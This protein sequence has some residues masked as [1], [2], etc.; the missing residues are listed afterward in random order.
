[1]LF[2]SFVFLWFLLLVVPL[3]SLLAKRWRNPLLLIASYVFYGYWDWRFCG[4]L[5]LSTVVDY[6]AGGR[7]A[8]SESE[9]GRRRWLWVSL[10]TN[11]G[12]LG[13][14]KY[15]NFFA[16]SFLAMLGPYSQSLDFVHLNIILPVGI[17]FYTFQTLSYTIDIYRERLE[18]ARSFWDFALFVSFFPQLV[19]GPIER[20]RHLLPQI[21]ERRL[22][23]RA[24]VQEAMV[25]ITLGMFRKV[26]IG[27]TCG[28]YVD[29]LFAEPSAYASGELLAA[30]VLFSIQIY[31]DFS[32]Y[33]SIARGTAKLLGVDLMEN[34]NQPYLAQNITEFWRRWHISLSSWLRDY[35]YISLGGNRRGRVR[36]Y[37]NLMTTMLLG[38]LWHGANWTF[39][40]W[41]GLHGL[42]LAVHKVMLGDRA[43]R[44]HFDRW[45]SMRDV[46]GFLSRVLATNAL[47]LLT[48]LFF[49]AKSFDH[50]W[51][52]LSR[53][54]AFEGSDLTGRF[55][56]IATAYVFLSLALDLAEYVT[57]DH[58]WPLR[59]PYWLR[60]PAGLVMWAVV[61][62][63]MFVAPP[64]PFIYFQF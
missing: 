32:G 60:A 57:R 54:L 33:S 43:I 50:A 13:I 9:A 26:I 11:L 29:T 19:A 48:W 56:Q 16:D 5:A 12:I 59:T 63:Y 61:L 24:M 49:R 10:A 4:L 22:P 27:D 1:M 28:R 46:A 51:E 35:L 58:A 7:I 53:M 42:Y 17:S 25:L 23:D 39:V 45:R 34:F 52:I 21:A 55:V 8:A 18:P 20:A 44:E 36:T 47:V 15:Y 31:A 62:M 3:H 30:L 2:N 40:V 14:F 38:G 6:I 64:M 41:G 37:A